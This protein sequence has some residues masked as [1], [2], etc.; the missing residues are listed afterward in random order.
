MDVST[1]NGLQDFLQSE[2]Y[3]D[4]QD[5]LHMRRKYNVEPWNYCFNEAGD[6]SAPCIIVYAL[7]LNAMSESLHVLEINTRGK[8]KGVL[9]QIDP[10]ASRT[11]STE[12]LFTGDTILPWQLTFKG[13]YDAQSDSMVYEHDAFSGENLCQ[14]GNF[15]PIPKGDPQRNIKS[16]GD[17][18]GKKSSGRKLPK[19][20]ASYRMIYDYYDIYLQYIATYACFQDRNKGQNLYRVPLLDTT[21][22]VNSTMSSAIISPE[23]QAYF[24]LFEDLDDFITKNYLEE[25]FYK[26]GKHFQ[27]IPC[28]KVSFIKYL[29]FTET[30]SNARG[31]RIF[32]DIATGKLTL[33][34]DI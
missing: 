31:R 13:V 1:F 26:D 30:F 7:L 18:K 3:W 17:I 2:P 29:K 12:L 9:C 27:L 16:L 34:A 33:S 32:T 14:I 5:W 25:L 20:T 4:F 15:M 19:G 11:T 6:T 21:R 28:H 8:N 10:P 23:L 22:E 24:G